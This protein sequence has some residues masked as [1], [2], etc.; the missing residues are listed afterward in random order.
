MSKKIPFTVVFF[1]EPNSGKEPVR[2][3]L[4]DLMVRKLIIK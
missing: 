4:K 2:D 1:Q 3:W